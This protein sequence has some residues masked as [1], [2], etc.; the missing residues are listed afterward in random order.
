MGRQ[1]RIK[2]FFTD[3]LQAA[4]LVNMQNGNDLEL[5]PIAGAYVPFKSFTL[6]SALSKSSRNLSLKEVW[7]EG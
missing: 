4:T 5:L 2:K 7:Q 3:E 6:R 1:L